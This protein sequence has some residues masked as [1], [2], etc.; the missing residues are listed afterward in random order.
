MNAA[1]FSTKLGA[2]CAKYPNQ[3]IAADELGV[4]YGTLTGWLGGRLPCSL[5]RAAVLRRIE[6]GTMEPVPA[7]SAME[8]AAECR[9]WRGRHGLSQI[10]AA[11]VLE[12]PRETIRRVEGMSRES[13]PLIADEIR[14]RLSRPIDPAALVIVRRRTRPVEP[15]ELAA[16]LRKW[17]RR[18]RMSRERAAAALKT[19]GFF[20]TGRTIWVWESARMLPRQPLV[21]MKMLE[22]RPPKQPRKPKP[23]KSF[24]RQLRAWRKARGLTQREAMTVLG[25]PG[26]QAKWSDWERG[27]KMP[28]NTAVLVARMEAAR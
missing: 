1:Q 10:R 9:V 3:H 21:L 12:L 22:A 5:S 6:S 2:W 23:D 28:K 14:R 26:D 19:M 11:A 17:R 27:K 24:G 25:V 7:V 8:L 20:T 18:Y 4:S 13:K 16:A 15:A